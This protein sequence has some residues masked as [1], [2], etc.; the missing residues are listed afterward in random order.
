MKIALAGLALCGA[1]ATLGAG[2]AY[3]SGF[4]L[5][6]NSAITNGE[7]DASIGAGAA[8]IS[9]ITTNPAGMVYFDGFQTSATENF[10][11]PTAHL[12]VASSSTNIGVASVPGSGGDGHDFTVSKYVPATYALWAPTDDLRVGIGL[13]VPF[14]LAT[15]YSSDSAVRYQAL[16]SEVTVVDINPS[17][18][19]KL[20]DWLSVGAGV[21]IERAQARLSNAIDFGTLVPLTLAKAGA[22]P[23]PLAE[24]L[25]AAGGSKTI[26]DGYADLAGNSWNA[27]YDIGFSAQLDA[28]TRA[29]ISYRSGIEQ[30]IK[31]TSTFQVPL[32]YRAIIA[33]TGAFQN[34]S[35]T[36]PLQ[37]PGNILVGL[38]NQ[39]TPE[40]RLDV[41]YQWTNWSKF[42]SIDVSFGNPYQPADNVIENYRDT[43]FVSVGGEYKVND[44]LSVRAGAAYDQ[45]PTQEIYRDIRLPDSDRYWIALGATYKLTPAIA[46][47]GSYQH[48]F[49]VNANVDHTLVETAGVQNLVSGTAS[50]SADVFGAEVSFKF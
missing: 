48:L 24:Q 5:R 44:Q 1:A 43:S 20:T 38:S 14:G 2:Q 3:A 39:V 13:S 28:T 49:F 45:A 22:I 4:A 10:I 19:Y 31:G 50:S 7:A 18:A 36:T 11:D 34:T 30:D 29:G 15:N 41:S 47:S 32:Q 8:D 40:L 23:L 25:I 37:L 17:A 27:G 26:N 21:T 6:E 16:V 46:L 42:Q 33:Q 12:N 9:T 35:A